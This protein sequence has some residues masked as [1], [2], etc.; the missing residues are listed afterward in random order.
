MSEGTHSNSP[1][2]TPMWRN[3][4]VLGIGTAAAAIVVTGVAIQFLRSNDGEAGQDTRQPGAAGRPSAVYMARVNKALISQEDLAQECIARY[5]Q[6]VLENIINRT[7]IQQACAEANVTVSEAEVNNEIRNIA[8]RFGIPV[9][10]WLKMLQ[11]ERGLTP[12]Q[13]QRDVIWPMLALKKLARE[14]VG[15]VADEDLKRAFYRDYGPRVKAKMIMLDNLRRAQTVWEEVVKTP[16]DFERLARRYSIEPNSRSLGG[17]IPP[18]RRYAGNDT[19]EKKAFALEPGE[20]S[21]IVQVGYNRYVILLC[22][23]RTEP[24]VTNIDEV[25]EELTDLIREEKVQ[26]AVANKFDE[27]KART[28]V[29][30]YLTNTSYGG[31]I[32]QVGGEKPSGSGIQPAG[33]SAEPMDPARAAAR[34]ASPLSV[35]RPPSDSPR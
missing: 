2:R 17:A 6:E 26:A 24:I 32:E 10:T 33:G 25:R 27:I 4:M 11:E 1:A 29:D 7:I 23:G 5:G 20:I 15:D 13:Y 30:N 28:R 35:A 12:A 22:E 9:D 3:K 19:L 18:I 21:G 34:R 16:N 14:E 8:K 31:N